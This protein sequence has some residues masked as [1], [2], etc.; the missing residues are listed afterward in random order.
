MGF[1]GSLFF[2]QG[3]ASAAAEAPTH[4][5]LPLFNRFR[6][7]GR[8]P[9]RGTHAR[10][11]FRPP[12][13]F[14][15]Q[16]KAFPSR[17]SRRRSLN[18][19]PLPRSIPYLNPSLPPKNCQAA[20]SPFIS[21]FCL[22]SRHRR[23]DPTSP[24]PAPSHNEILYC[25][26]LLLFDCSPLVS[27]TAAHCHPCFVA[28]AG[29]CLSR[30]PR[31]R[32]RPTYPSLPPSDRAAA[33]ATVR[34]AAWVGRRGRR[35]DARDPPNLFVTRTSDG[36]PAC[37]LAGLLAQVTFALIHSPL[38]VFYS[39]AFDLIRSLQVCCFQL[40][41]G[42]RRVR[43]GTESGKQSRQEMSKCAACGLASFVGLLSVRIVVRKQ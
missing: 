8:P 33:A 21:C 38:V 34:A 25:L 41:D 32:G 31:A 18:F 3:G 30:K 27:L 12:M 17:S 29:S 19:P 9:G 16:A 22:P 6:G 28:G 37:G 4:P 13:P 24:R 15:F 36:A 14:Y 1:S 20:K 5:V 23:A 39:S 7:G 26:P 42:R 11:L 35:W 43:N 2:F 10:A 40:I